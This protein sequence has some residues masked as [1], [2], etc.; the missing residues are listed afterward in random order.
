MKY[1]VKYVIED[2]EIGKDFW[3]S[4]KELFESFFGDFYDYILSKN[5]DDLEK[6][7]IFS[8]EDFYKYADYYADGM[9]NCYAM[10]F[11]FYPYYLNVKLGGK[12]EEQNDSFLGFLVKEK[13]YQNFLNFL[14]SFFAYWRNDEG[15]TT[16]D[17]YNYADDFFASSWASLVDTSKLFYFSAETVYAWQSFRVKYTL[18]NIPGVFKTDFVE[19]E[20]LEENTMLK[21]ISVAGYEFLGYYN[22]DGEKVTF[23][24]KNEVLTLKFRQKDTYNYWEKEE[25]KIKK[26][27]DPNYKKPDPA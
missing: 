10:G 25:K 12:L 5:K 19:E 4:K 1:K 9:E 6:R 22:K 14:I 17:P 16:F 8:K 11:S 7:K 27:Y 13:K 23:A 24:S 15:C 26:V 21:K 3:L 18:D 20:V 2:H